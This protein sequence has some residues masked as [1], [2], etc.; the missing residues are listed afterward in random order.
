M[1]YAVYVQVPTGEDC[2]LIARSLL[3]VAP[4][5]LGFSLREKGD[6]SESADVE[7]CFR[8]RGVS[9]PEEAL[10]KAL[11]LYARGRSAA[12]LERDDHAR[13]RLAE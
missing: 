10:S 4:Q 9:H 6:P 11:D 2:D 3:A 7:L 1:E 5:G 13:A 8:I 12:G